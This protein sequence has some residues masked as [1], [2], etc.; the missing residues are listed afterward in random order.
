MFDNES[1]FKCDFTPLLNYLNIKPVLTKIKNPQAKTMVEW[2]HQVILKMLYT[3]DTYN[4]VLNSTDP[5][6]ET[7]AYIAWVIME[8]YQNTI[9]TTSYQSVFGIYMIFNFTSLVYWKVI[10]ASEK[11]QVD[12]ENFKKR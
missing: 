10:N 3:K 2:V 9:H 4:K 7:L 5:W 12:I 1:E 6:S 8:Y 11:R